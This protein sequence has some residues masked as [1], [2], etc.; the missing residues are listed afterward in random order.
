M[1]WK[2]GK[3]LNARIRSLTGESGILRYSGKEIDLDMKK[4]EERLIKF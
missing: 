4:N 1:E 3:L 2:E